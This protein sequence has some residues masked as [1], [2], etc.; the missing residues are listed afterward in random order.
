MRS[1]MRRLM[2]ALGPVCVPMTAFAAELPQ[3]GPRPWEINL[4]PAATPVMEQLESFHNLLLWVIFAIGFFVLGLLLYASWRF[5]EERN[6]TPS[7]RT[8]NTLLEITWTVVPVLILVIIAIPSFKLLYFMD[9]TPHTDLTI[10]ATG[11]QWYWTYDYPDSGKFTFD[12]NLVDDSDLKP[13][14]PR[15]LTADNPMV[16]PVGVNVR[17]LTTATDVIHDWSMPSF[18]VKIDAIPGRLNETWFHVNEPGIY[19][20]Q[21]DQLCGINHGYM[22]IMV[23]AVP[24]PEFDAWAKEAKK[25][26]AQIDGGPG[27]SR[28]VAGA[29]A[30]DRIV[31]AAAAPISA[32]TR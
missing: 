4:Q 11:H 12:A 2:L 31:A 29:G 27:D 8:H 26:F 15:L 21:C 3:H 24:K 13:G 18:G 14:Q 16:V 17:L 32:P 30:A 5:R 10:K 1:T 23:K 20:G 22:P 19:Y 25:E 28:A 9:V 7:R 6:P